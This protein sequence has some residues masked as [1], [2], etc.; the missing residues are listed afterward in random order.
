[1]TLGRRA[2]ELAADVGQDH[3]RKLESLGL[4]HRHDAHAFGA[5]LEN[6]RFRRLRPCGRGPELVDK[7]AERQ[8]TL[9][10]VL[11]R[12]LLD[13]QHVGEDLLAAAPQDEAGVRARQLEE[14]ADRL[15]DGTVIALAMQLRQRA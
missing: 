3:D 1:M 10:F 13:L 6:R 15:G 14:P 7:A 11:P 8:A 4:V 5:F 9:G 2:I 12:E